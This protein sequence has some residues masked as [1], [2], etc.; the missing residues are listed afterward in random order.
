MWGGGRARNA[1][2]PCTRTAHLNGRQQL[3]SLPFIYLNENI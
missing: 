1:A 3:R 2:P